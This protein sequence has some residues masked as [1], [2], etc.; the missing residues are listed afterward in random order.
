MAFV[1]NW[2]VSKYNIELKSKDISELFWKDSYTTLKL[3]SG[4]AP[5]FLQQ[6]SSSSVDFVI[7]TI[8]M[9]QM[10]EGPSFFEGIG[11]TV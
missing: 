2:P 11:Y 1:P 8:G 9:E 4:L 6:V 7:V 10:S 5:T 3:I